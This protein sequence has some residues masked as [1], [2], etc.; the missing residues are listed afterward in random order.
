MVELLLMRVNTCR[1]MGNCGIVQVV[2]EVD[3]GL[4]VF[5]LCSIKL[6][7]FPSSR[8]LAGGSLDFCDGN[9]CS[10][11]VFELDEVRI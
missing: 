4:W 3:D 11:V 6:G 7:F 2:L 10:V 8:N 1:P 5:K 9:D